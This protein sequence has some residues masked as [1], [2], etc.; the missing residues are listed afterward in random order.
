[1]RIEEFG[2]FQQARNSEAKLQQ[3]RRMARALA[4]VLNIQPGLA[5]GV[6]LGVPAPVT[7]QEAL[8]AWVRDALCTCEGG[9]EREVLTEL[10]RKFEKIMAEAGAF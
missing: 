2:P 8:E 1:M 7:H 10:A 9:S 6:L 4:Q 3:S 5:L